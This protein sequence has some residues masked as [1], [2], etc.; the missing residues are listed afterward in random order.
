MHWNKNN[1]NNNNNKV[2]DASPIGNKNPDQI[3][4][5]SA[6]QI[7]IQN[8]AIKDYHEFHRRPHKDLKMLILY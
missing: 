3:C 5:S 4:Y 1:D 7:V 2:R 6:D 8:S